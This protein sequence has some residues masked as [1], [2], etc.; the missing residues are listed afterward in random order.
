MATTLLPPSRHRVVFDNAWGV[1]A[2]QT[3]G[4]PQYYGAS[5]HR[6][7]EMPWAGADIPGWALVGWLAGRLVRLSV[8]SRRGLVRPDAGVL[9]RS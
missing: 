8:G 9:R 1:I 6:L 5:R 3:H 7:Y 4:E 2:G